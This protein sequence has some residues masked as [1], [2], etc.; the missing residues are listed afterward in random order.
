MSIKRI[1]L[2]NKIC[3]KLPIIFT[4]AGI[5]WCPNTEQFITLHGRRILVDQADAEAAKQRDEIVAR[6]LSGA[7]DLKEYLGYQAVFA[8]IFQNISGTTIPV[9]NHTLTV[10]FPSDARMGAIER[11]R[12]RLEMP[13]EYEKTYLETTEGQVYSSTTA[14]TGGMFGR[15]VTTHKGGGHFVT[16]ITYNAVT[17]ESITTQVD[18]EERVE[19]KLKSIDGVDII[20]LDYKID[21][22]QITLIEGMDK[23]NEAAVTSCF[24][25]PYFGAVGDTKGYH[26]DITNGSMYQHWIDEVA[27]IE[28][29]NQLKCLD[30][31]DKV[32]AENLHTASSTVTMLRS[33][34][35]GYGDR[36]VMVVT[37]IVDR[38]G[39]VWSRLKSH[40]RGLF[41][42]QP[43]CEEL[44]KW[45][46][47]LAGFEV[48][49][50]MDSNDETDKFAVKTGAFINLNSPNMYGVFSDEKAEI[51]GVLITIIRK[52]VTN[53]AVEYPVFN[54]SHL[55]S[56]RHSVT[57]HVPDFSR[58][59]DVLALVRDRVNK[60][61]EG[62]EHVDKISTLKI[63]EQSIASF[64]NNY[65]EN[66]SFLEDHSL[67]CLY[68]MRALWR[69]LDIPNM[70]GKEGDLFRR[71]EAS[72][73]F[74]EAINILGVEVDKNNP[75]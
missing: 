56:G 50:T 58:V 24:T 70:P 16:N 36:T 33:H 15:I 25:I 75:T 60:A 6:A 59:N 12:V 46:N 2:D 22:D 27:L 63:T 61:L 69:L 34:S 54:L 42:Y 10:M 5:G 17:H 37:N 52:V 62:T 65:E 20:M 3:R 29:A 7:I 26:K 57:I 38:N 30:V 71:V 64:T 28:A 40:N 1:I 21:L 11:L 45:F 14:R 74:E 9:D 48:S 18:G 53:L 73:V 66:M 32:K 43:N 68:A 67:S 47:K 39:S 19:S 8:T 13:E 51:D 23:V 4:A 35:E 44:G 41:F 49:V 55:I 72:V 31:M